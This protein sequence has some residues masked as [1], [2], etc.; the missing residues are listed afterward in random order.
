MFIHT[1]QSSSLSSEPLKSPSSKFRKFFT[2]TNLAL[3]TIALLA[4]G[5]LAGRTSCLANTLG[6]LPPID[7]SYP[8]VLMAVGMNADL[9]A[10]ALLILYTGLTSKEKW[11][12]DRRSRQRRDGERR[13]GA[14]ELEIGLSMADGTE[15]SDVRRMPSQTQGQGPRQSRRGVGLGI[16]SEG[17]GWGGRDVKEII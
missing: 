6:A 1:K 10:A 17:I 8:L 2:P 5:S 4:F 12:A 9:S 3:L 16:S 11:V 7:E 15:N 13:L 14:L